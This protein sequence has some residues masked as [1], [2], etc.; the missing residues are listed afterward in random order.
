MCLQPAHIS[1][2][3]LLASVGTECVDTFKAGLPGAVISTLLW[4]LA[5]DVPHTWPDV[6]GETEQF[7][8]K[9]WKEQGFSE[10]DNVILKQIPADS[11]MAKVVVYT[12]EFPGAL[13]IGLPFIRRVEKLL[14]QQEQIK[15]ELLRVDDTTRRRLLERELALIET[16]LDECRFVCGHERV[17]QEQGHAYKIL[18]TQCVAPFAV[19]VVAQQSARILRKY[20]RLAWIA[21]CLEW[22]ATRSAAEIGIF[23]LKAHLYEREADLHAS[24]DPKVIEAGISLFKKAQNQKVPEMG[25]VGYRTKLMSWLL[26]YT[27]PILSERIW[28]LTTALKKLRS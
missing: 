4:C 12:Q 9:T 18:I 21:P 10:A 7:I 11:F 22:K 16:E 14:A 19:Y 13:A 23:W 20:E 25:P 24:T 6:T 26:K 3:S 2:S 1:P 28:Y 17:H 5:Y 27:H 8:R 15:K